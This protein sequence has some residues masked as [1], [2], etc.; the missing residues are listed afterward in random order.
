MECKATVAKANNSNFRCDERA[1]QAVEERQRRAKSRRRTDTQYIH[2]V[3]ANWLEWKETATLRRIWNT[4]KQ[5]RSS[6]NCMLVMIRKIEEGILSTLVYIQCTQTQKH[7]HSRLFARSPQSH[8]HTN[9]FALQEDLLYHI[10]FVVHLH[11]FDPRS[12]YDGKAVSLSIKEA[13]H[14]SASNVAKNQI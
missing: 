8:A 9:E 3:A 1:T 5:M 10:I 2:M 11:R 12:G 13:P 14:M 7:T 6:R 4:T